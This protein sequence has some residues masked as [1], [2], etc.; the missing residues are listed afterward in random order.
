MA[1]AWFVGKLNAVFTS[2]NR[3]TTDVLVAEK[4]NGPTLEVMSVPWLK[5]CASTVID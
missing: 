1:V 5:A 3:L 2:G 4:V